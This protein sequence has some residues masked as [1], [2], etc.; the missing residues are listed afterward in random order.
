MKLAVILILVCAGICAVESSKG[1][2]WARSW[3]N[4]DGPEFASKKIEKKSTPLQKK[5]VLFTYGSVN[6]GYFFIVAF[7]L[8][9]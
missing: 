4:T 9:P 6:F 2:A 8:N 5:K 1:S 7:I 3:G